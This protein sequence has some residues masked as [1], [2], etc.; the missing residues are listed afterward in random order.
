MERFGKREGGGGG[1]W[2]STCTST[3]TQA[4]QQEL[5]GE[6]SKT[7]SSFAVAISNM[8]S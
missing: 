2:R 5:V 4:G 6:C 8:H 3:K 7:D 1:G